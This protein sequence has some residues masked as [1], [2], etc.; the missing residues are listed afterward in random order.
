MTFCWRITLRIIRGPIPAK[1]IF[2]RPSCSD[3]L[4][5]IEPNMPWRKPF[6]CLGAW[7]LRRRLR[8]Q[9]VKNIVTSSPIAAA[10]FA[11]MKAAIALSRSPL[12]TI[13]V[14]LLVSIAYRLS[15]AS[16]LEGPEQVVGDVVRTE[17]HTSELQSLRHLVC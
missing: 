16:G 14:F 6:L 9:K 1:F 7:G 17:E 2:E 11:I 3:P 5:I 13:S 10:P 15:G 8:P 4:G 12:K